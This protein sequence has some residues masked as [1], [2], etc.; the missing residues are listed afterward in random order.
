[1]ENVT[2]QRNAFLFCRYGVALM[3][4]GALFVEGARAYLLGAVFVIMALSWAL[5]V[6]RAPMVWIY[7]QT[8][9]RFIPSKDVVLDVKAMR[10]AHGLGALLAL[11][12]LSL[13][14]RDSPLAI[15]FVIAFAALK[16]ASALGACPAYKLYGCLTKGGGCCAI[17][18]K[19]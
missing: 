16:T 4:W 9:G 11:I 15:Y 12:C 1:V 13:V 2:I 17:T 7:T 18:G 10:V 5:K 3:V 14:L 6:H 8:F 19:R